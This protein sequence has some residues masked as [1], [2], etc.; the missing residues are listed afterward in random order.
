MHFSRFLCKDYSKV[1]FKHAEI[2]DA[3]FS[4]QSLLLRLMV[5]SRMAKKNTHAM[6]TESL[7]I[8]R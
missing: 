4:G 2:S 6:T 5:A 7:F 3:I 8:V 1:G